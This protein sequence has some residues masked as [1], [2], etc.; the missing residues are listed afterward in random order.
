VFDVRL[1]GR[2]RSLIGLVGRLTALAGV[3]TGLAVAIVALGRAAGWWWEVGCA[4][5]A[6][7]GPLT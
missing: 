1:H 6:R 2:W 7:G 4:G 5:G 3:M